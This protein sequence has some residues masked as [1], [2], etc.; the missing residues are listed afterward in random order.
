VSLSGVA[1]SALAGNLDWTIALP[2]AGG[3]LAGMLGGRRLEPAQPHQPGLGIG[4]VGS[5]AR[6]MLGRL[7]QISDAA[8][9]C[10][11]ANIQELRLLCCHS[12]KLSIKA[13]GPP[14]LSRGSDPRRPRLV[15]PPCATRGV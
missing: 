10:G 15:L 7:L 3:A 5:A 1:S 14:A 9:P 6:G 11:G 2:F 13:A 8:A 12:I 4:V